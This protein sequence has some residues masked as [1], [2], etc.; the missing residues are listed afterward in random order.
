MSEAVAITPMERFLEAAYDLFNLKEEGRGK[1]NTQYIDVDVRLAENRLPESAS[2]SGAAVRYEYVNPVVFLTGLRTREMPG[3]PE[4]PTAPSPSLALIVG[5]YGL[6]KTEL[7]FQVC[8][9]MVHSVETALPVNLALCRDREH[10]AVLDRGDVTAEEMADLLFGRIVERAGLDRSFTMEELLPA[11]RNGN[12]LLLLDGLDELIS[13]PTQHHAFFAGLMTF[14]NHRTPDAEDP[15]YKVVIS[16]RFEYLAGVA[17]DARDLVGRLRVPVYYLV[18]D[19]LG[20]RGVA[21]YLRTRLPNA[22]DLFVE[23]QSH[24]FLIDMFRR[25]LLLRIFCDLALRHDFDLDRLMKTLERQKSPAALLEAFIDAASQ[26]ARL[27]KEQDQLGHVVWDAARLSEKSLDLYRDGRTEFTV[28]DLREVIVPLDGQIS[29]DEMRNLAPVDVL[30]GVH[31]CPFLRQDAIGVDLETSRVARFAH[32]IFY[33]YFTSRG[34]AAEITH[35]QP[36]ANEKKR[37]FDELVLNVDMRKFLRGL[38]ESDDRWRHETKRSYGL[39]DEADLEEWKGEGTTDFQEL[40][41]RRWTLLQFMTDP[42]HPPAEIRDTIDWFLERQ[43]QWLHPRYLVYNYEA[44]A[45]YLWYERR[46]AE[47]ANVRS[48]FGEI[49]RARFDGLLDELRNLPADAADAGRAD[50]LLLERLLDIAR[51]LRYSWVARWA[52]KAE[53]QKLMAIIGSADADV[54]N[55]VARILG[56][57]RVTVF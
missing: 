35:P 7:V 31:K 23:I 11:I 55:R 54:A 40:D 6:G 22:S 42:E 25:P 51:R 37:A 33:E 10:L 27:R 28:A 21:S 26:D 47:L 18:L 1:R 19:Y 56:D 30:K 14:V 16:M 29:L 43:K 38:L 45:V 2:G 46:N 53:E 48:S 44:V 32:R 3:K 9:H 5:Q 41:D 15:F 34:M 24:A 57:I 8:H 12:V 20:D 39:V 4:Q 13:T 50:R 49:L 36:G 52:D 17:D